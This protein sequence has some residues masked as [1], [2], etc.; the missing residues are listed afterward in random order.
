MLMSPFSIMRYEVCYFIAIY[1]SWLIWASLPDMVQTPDQ[2]SPNSALV[3][4][5]HV[6]PANRMQV[7]IGLACIFPGLEKDSVI[8]DRIG[9]LVYCSDYHLT[10]FTLSYPSPISWPDLDLA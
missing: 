5:R 7:S 6:E 2:G 10:E 9:I 3:S 1:N 8:C 4:T